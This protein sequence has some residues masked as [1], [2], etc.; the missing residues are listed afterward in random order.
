VVQLPPMWSRLR[1]TIVNSQQYSSLVH[2]DHADPHRI[3]DGS[4]RHKRHR[5]ELPVPSHTQVLELANTRILYQSGG[6][7][8][9]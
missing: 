6:V 5:V 9:L 8:S 7:E 2:K 4:F 3:T 1:L